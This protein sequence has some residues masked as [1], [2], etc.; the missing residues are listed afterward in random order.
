VVVV[1]LVEEL[2]P[3][4]VPHQVAVASV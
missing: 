4:D 2:Q 3:G 1:D